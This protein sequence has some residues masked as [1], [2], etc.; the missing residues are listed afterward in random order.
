[1]FSNWFSI[2][3]ACPSCRILTDRGEHDYFL[4][5][6]L[7]NFIAAELLVAAASLGTLLITWPAPPWRI[8]LY[9]SLFLAVVFPIIGYP[10]SKT[11]WLAI[12]LA[13]R[14]PVREGE[15]QAHEDEPL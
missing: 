6:I 7:V 5:A 10:Y 14:D 9:G 1:M 8:I 4:G 2:R 3:H 12:D 15:E 11:I 13:I